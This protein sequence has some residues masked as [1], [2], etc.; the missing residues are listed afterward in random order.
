M[1][2]A[3]QTST[4]AAST[5]A[6]TS[7]VITK[8]A[9]TAN[10]DLLITLGSL[11][12]GEFSG[13]DSVDWPGTTGGA[14]IELS[15]QL[16]TSANTL[17]GSTAYRNAGAS[18]PSTYTINKFDTGSGT[19]EVAVAM[20]RINGHTGN[21]T[22]ASAT[23]TGTSPD[24]PNLTGGSTG[25]WIV[26][27]SVDNGTTVSTEPTDYTV[28]QEPFDADQVTTW[29]GDHDTASR[30]PAQA[31]NPGAATIGTSRPW[32]AFTINVADGEAGG[33]DGTDLPWPDFII[34]PPPPLHV[35]GY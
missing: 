21:P 27:L 2:A 6:V 28:L 19:D 8:P 11:A 20:L 9:M 35:V 31:S 15:E 22:D 30:T 13:W 26:G 17:S 3:V 18:E 5:S 12:S 33:G 16:H 29:L 25:L 34:P 10:G 24:P 23:G 1:A 7:I 32:C 14:F 4:G